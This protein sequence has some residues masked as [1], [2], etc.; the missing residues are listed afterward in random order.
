MS[1]LHVRL[2][3]LARREYRE[4]RD[5]YDARQPGL[6]ATFTAEIDLAVQR[7][8]EAPDRWPIF[9]KSYRFFLVRR[10]PYVLYYKSIDPE[11]VLVLAVAHGRRIP[12][13]WLGRAYRP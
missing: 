4:A 5:W 8:G 1:S 6:G 11:T 10:F 3:R 7:I 9:R 2:H 12:G 13:Y